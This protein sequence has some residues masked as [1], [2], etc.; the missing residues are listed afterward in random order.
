MTTVLN[1]YVAQ[2]K[3]DLAKL[4]APAQEFAQIQ[5]DISGQ[6]GARNGMTP[7]AVINLKGRNVGQFKQ[8]VQNIANK[9]SAGVDKPS[10]VSVFV[11]YNA[12]NPVNATQAL[13]FSRNHQDYLPKGQ[14]IDKI[15]PEQFKDNYLTMAKELDSVAQ[16]INSGFK[17]EKI[18]IDHLPYVMAPNTPPVEVASSKK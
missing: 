13:V 15:T 10:L 1:N 12:K 14:M 11:L 2:E 3:T 7:N 18:F 17:K 6:I 4:Q 9:I 5:G 16:R 8:D